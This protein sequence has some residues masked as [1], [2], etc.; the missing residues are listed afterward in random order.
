MI[1]VKI[2][3]PL[4]CENEDA[5]ALFWPFAQRFI[6]TYFKHRPGYPSVV[7]VVV[8][9]PE[10]TGDIVELFH[11]MPV[12]FKLYDGN[13]MDLGSQQMVAQ[14]GDHFQVNLTTRMYFHR[15]GWLERMMAARETYGPGLYGMTASHEGGKLHLCT[16]GHAY[17]SKDFREYPH[18]IISRDQG[19]FFECGDGC[20]LEWYQAR[21]QSALV[22]GWDGVYGNARCAHCHETNARGFQDY[23]V[24]QDNFRNGDQRNVLC[25]DKHTDSYRDADAEEKQRLSDLWRGP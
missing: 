6:D 8:N 24:S 11:G 4:P 14:E 22:V 23:F 21:A 13:G 19:V 25:F 1:P 2:V 7:T 20:L 15:E 9:G 3:Y 12:E 17:D 16:R 10:V 5:K 18:K